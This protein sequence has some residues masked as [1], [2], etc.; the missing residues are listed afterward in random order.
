MSRRDRLRAEAPALT[1]LA[2]LLAVGLVLRVLHNDYGLPYVYYADE[3]S[4][5]TNRAVGM[6]GGDANPHYFQN[7]SGF[8]YLVHVALRLAFGHGNPFGGFDHVIAAYG[9]HPTRIYQVARTVAALVCLVGV[10]GV[11]FVGRALWDRRTGLVAAA[12]LCFSFLIVAY[13]R[14]AVTDVGTLLPVALALWC[15]VRLHERGGWRWAAGAGAAVGLAI[16]FKYTAGLVILSP[17]LAL[18]LR[19]RADW[20]AAALGLGALLGCLLVVFFVTTPYFFLDFSTAWHQLRYQADLAGGLSKYGQEHDNGLLYYA[21]SLTWGLGWVPLAAAI[22]GAVLLLRRDRARAALLVIFPL[23]LFIYL[24]TQSRYFGRWFLP[25]YPAFALLAAYG[26]VQGLSALLAVR[27]L[28]PRLAPAALVA[29]VVVLVWQAVAADTRS[30]AVLG[31]AD[32]RQVARTWLVNNMPSSL[33]IVIEPAVPARY[34]W[35]LTPKGEHVPKAKQFVR[36]FLR[37]ISE[38]RIEYGRT[39]SPAV[40]D[41]YRKHGYCLVMTMSLIRGRTE[42]ARNPRAL[43]YYRALEAQSTRVFSVSPWRFGADE[44]AFNFDLSYNYYSPAYV[45]PG[46]KIDIYRLDDCTQGF[47]QIEAGA[48]TP[49][50]AGPA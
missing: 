1:V 8:T 25:A 18:A 15:A 6:L 17:L 28:G 46:P 39:L 34:Y 30:M 44:Q 7:P 23:A 42:N 43:A 19:A 4:H 29:A 10:A 50:G 14:I 11:Y 36:G 13:S 20:K 22:A 21:G 26:T 3:G 5:F 32:T 24:A 47:G 48:G 9:E 37:D 33:R 12:V 16:G 45:R 2:A 35:R 31:H 38:T 49:Q 40:L 27:R 41:S